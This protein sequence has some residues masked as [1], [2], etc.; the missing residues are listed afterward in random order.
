MNASAAWSEVIP[1][2]RIQYHFDNLYQDMTMVLGPYVL[3]QLGDLSCNPGYEVPAHVQSVHEISYIVSGRGQMWIDDQCISLKPH[4]LVLN[5]IGDRHRIQA[6]R[7]EGLR[8]FYLGFSFSPF[9]ATDSSRMLETFFRCTVNRVM[10]EAQDLQDAFIAFFTE[11][12]TRDAVSEVML[13]ACMH[14][15]VCGAWRLFTQGVSTVY[16]FGIARTVDRDLVCDVVHYIDNQACEPGLLGRISEKFGYSY[17]HIARRFALITGQSLRSY[18]SQRRFEIA[19]GHL[20]NG[21]SVTEV[22]ELMGYKSIHAFSNAFKKHLGT[23]PSDYLRQSSAISTTQ[24][25][26]S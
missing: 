25:E 16:R 22:A 8:Y 13:E 14:R 21:S 18:Y 17:K 15:V 1:L 26:K 9:A 7:L 10:D 2:E 19:C 6:D 3:F 12:L 20:K 4:M 23:S 24:E 5:R 11:L